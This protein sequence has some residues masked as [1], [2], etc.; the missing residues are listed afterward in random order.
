MLDRSPGLAAHPLRVGASRQDPHPYLL[1]PIRH[2][3]YAG[4]TALHVAAAAHHRGIAESLVARGAAVRARNRRGAEP[5]HYAADG[6]PG[7]EDSGPDAQRDVISY[8][9]DAGADPDAVDKSGV[10]P[11]HRAVRSRCSGAVS[12]LIDRGADP[13]RMNK[14][15]STPL[16]LAVQNTGK[17]NSGSAAAKEEQH[18]IIVLL[19]EHGASGTDLDA[20]GKTVTAAASSVWIRQLLDGYEPRRGR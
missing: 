5:L 8:L 18:R 13:L 20:K 3:V 16:H 12:A 7:G 9:I 4:D 17:G 6:H 1:V 19:L 11:L 10:A 14:S 2:Y 15:G